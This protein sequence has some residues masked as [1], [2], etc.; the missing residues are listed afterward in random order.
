MEVGLE[1]RREEDLHVPWSR[2]TVKL[3]SPDRKAF[4]TVFCPELARMIRAHEVDFDG[5]VWSLRAPAESP[6]A[7]NF[8]EVT[9]AAG[10]GTQ[11]PA[12]TDAPPAKDA[13][14]EPETSEGV[15]FVGR[16]MHWLRQQGPVGKVAAGST[17]ILSL[18][19]G[20][21]RSSRHWPLLTAG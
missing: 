5:E 12:A 16:A 14:R 2:L 10:P 21:N 20:K 13:A 7:S 11:G 18:P 15:L 19:A 9:G 1:R 17:R 3:F 8:S 4:Q 6:P